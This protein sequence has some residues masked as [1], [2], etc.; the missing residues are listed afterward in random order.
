MNKK[1]LLKKKLKMYYYYTII[2][3]SRGKMRFLQLSQ[4]EILYTGDSFKIK[5]NKKK[6]PN[7]GNLKNIKERFFIIN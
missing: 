2:R 3:V 6:E 5:K 7:D 4:E 1:N